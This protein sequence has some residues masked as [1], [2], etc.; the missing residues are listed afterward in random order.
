MF[1]KEK[2]SVIKRLYH[3]ATSPSGETTKVLNF[4]VA[5]FL[6]VQSLTVAISDKLFMV[7]SYKHY[8]F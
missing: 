1:G 5:T 7:S 2:Y 6:V 3:L 8:Y 4:V